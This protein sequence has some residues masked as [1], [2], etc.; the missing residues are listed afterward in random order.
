MEYKINPELANQAKNQ[1]MGGAFRVWVLSRWLDPKG[2]GTVNKDLLRSGLMNFGVEKRTSQR[3]IKAAY[4]N[5]FITTRL[6]L[7]YCRYSSPAGLAVILGVP[8]L[9]R[10]VLIEDPKVFFCSSWGLMI[11]DCLIASLEGE[12]ING[13]TA[14]RATIKDISGVSE[15]TQRLYIRDGKTKAIRNAAVIKKGTSERYHEIGGKIRLWGDW[16]VRVM[17]RT[18]TS[19]YKTAR[20]G[21]IKVYNRELNNLVNVEQEKKDKRYFH[22]YHR[23]AKQGREVYLFRK[24][25]RGTNYWQVLGVN[26]A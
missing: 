20:P 4:N 3:W 26:I 8:S 19:P 16:L 5:G 25:R 7:N 12:G 10:P 17:P 22:N 18:H 24:H 13:F 21:R 11:F 23:A 14:S 1:N 2:S 9:G 6:G 15:R